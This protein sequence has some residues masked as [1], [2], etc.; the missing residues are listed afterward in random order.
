[1]AFFPTHQKHSRN[2]QTFLLFGD[3]YLIDYCLRLDSMSFCLFHPDPTSHYLFFSFSNFCVVYM[4][5]VCLFFFSLLVLQLSDSLMAN[6]C[7]LKSSSLFQVIWVRIIVF[8][9]LLLK[10][11]LLWL[12]LNLEFLLLK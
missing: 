9:F 5:N 8:F 10:I 12:K 6:L 2:T 3:V 7:V 1:M 4:H 11:L